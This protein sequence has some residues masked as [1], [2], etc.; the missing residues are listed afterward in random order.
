MVGNVADIAVRTTGQHTRRSWYSFALLGTWSATF[1]YVV[2]DPTQVA[3]SESWRR[4]LCCSQL[5]CFLVEMFLDCTSQ[6]SL[7][8][9]VRRKLFELNIQHYFCNLVRYHYTHVR[10]WLRQGSFVLWFLV[11]WLNGGF[12]WVDGQHESNGWF[13]MDG[14]ASA[15]LIYRSTEVLVWVWCVCAL[16]HCIHP[17]HSPQ[18][19]MPYPDIYPPAGS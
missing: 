1:T 17:S 9:G 2:E 11:Y 19:W 4:N 14:R 12:D 3:T 10:L 8:R 15:W 7:P 6:C 13:V 16:Y 5:M 18:S